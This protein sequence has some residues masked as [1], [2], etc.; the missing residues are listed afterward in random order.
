MTAQ[1]QAVRVLIVEDNE[2]HA[3]LAV[4]VLES[5]GYACTHAAS[6][7]QALELVAAAAPDLVLMDLMLPGMSG[8]QAIGRLRAA[9]ATRALR[10]IAVTSYRSEFPEEDFLR[11]GA[12]GHIAKPYHYANLIELARAVLARSRCGD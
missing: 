4:K 2:A 5:A 9:E 8:L 6:A 7:E 10:I 12:D 3:R 1:T 11:S